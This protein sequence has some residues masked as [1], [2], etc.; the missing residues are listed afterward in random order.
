MIVEDTTRVPDFDPQRQII[1]ALRRHKDAL[2]GVVLRFGEIA[3]KSKDK[4]KIHIFFEFETTRLFLPF[5]G[6]DGLKSIEDTYDYILTIDPY[7]AEYRNK[8]L[9][10]NK[11]IPVFHPIPYIPPDREKNIDAIYCGGINPLIE[12]IQDIPNLQIVSASHRGPKTHKGVSYEKKIELMSRSKITVCQNMWWIS[13]KQRKRIE[14]RPELQEIESVKYYESGLTTELKSR[15]FEAAACKSLILCW[16][17]RHN[18]V[19]RFFKKDEF[20][21]C[22]TGTDIRDK[23]NHI[24]SHY[25]EYQPMI[26][27]AHKR[28]KNNYTTTHLIKVIE[29]CLKSSS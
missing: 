12:S 25:E 15:M 6:K 16:H 19:E 29:K 13:G 3:R 17:D 2:P 14:A 20:V 5:D 18:I 24:V 23:I 21:Y 9:G 26:L 10:T 11:Y 4:D 22:K 28:A 1:K 7:T 27:A 8:T